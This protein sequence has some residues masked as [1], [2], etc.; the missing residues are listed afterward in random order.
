MSFQYFIYVC[1]LEFRLLNAL[2]S[3]SRV[4]AG[5][6][7]NL[8]SYEPPWLPLDFV[9]FI[10]HSFWYDCNRIFYFRHEHLASTL[11]SKEPRWSGISAPIK[12]KDSVLSALKTQAILSKQWRKWMVSYTNFKTYIFSILNTKHKWIWQTN[13]SQYSSTHLKKSLLQL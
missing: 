9:L 11:P 5:I 4:M 6:R 2:L 1:V 13:F 8:I 12:A 10:H 7:M 3:L